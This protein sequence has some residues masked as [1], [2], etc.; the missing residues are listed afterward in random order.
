V[1]P[2]IEALDEPKRGSRRHDDTVRR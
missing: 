2:T 1:C